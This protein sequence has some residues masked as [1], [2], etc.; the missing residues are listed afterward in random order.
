MPRFPRAG[1]LL[2]GTCLAAAASG[3]GAQAPRLEIPRVPKDQ[4][5]AFALYT[6]H[7]GVLKLTAQLYPLEASDPKVVRLEVERGG[8]WK[9]I[10]RALVVN[11]GWTA[12]FRV[13]GWD[14][15]HDVRYRVRHGEDAVFEGL[16]RKDPVDKEEIVVAAFTGNSNK[17]R[18]LKPDLIANLE[19]QD[20]DLLFFSGDQSYDHQDH[21]YAWLLFGRQFA[22]IVR[23]RPTVTIP[24]DH[25]VGQANLWGEGGK[26]SSSVAGDDG[27]YFM[28]PEYVNEVQRAQTSHLPDPWD[29]ALVDQGITVYYTALTVG[30]VSF[31]IVEDRKWKTGPL[32]RVPQMGPRPDHVGFPPP[33]EYDPGRVDVAGAELLGERQLAFLR[34]WAADWRGADMKAVLSQTVFSGTAHVHAGQRL[35][36]DLDSNGWPQ[37]GRRRA[38][39]EMRRGFAFHIAGDQ[40]LASVVRYGIEDWDDAGFAFCVPSIVN[41]YPREWKPLEPPAAPVEGPLEHLGR[42]RDGLGNRLTMHA[43]ANPREGVRVAELDDLNS[44]ASGYGLVRFDKRTRRI[45]V[46]CWPRFVDVTRED[47]RQF[48]GWPVVIDQADNDGRSPFGTLPT[49]EIESRADPVVQVLEEATGEIVYTLRIQGRRFTPRVFRPGRYTVRV[50]EPG[51]MT[52]LTGLEAG[53]G[54]APPLRVRVP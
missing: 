3:A 16:V 6:V 48:P 21:L 17:D 37:S 9:E 7:D 31:A 45:T 34:A 29:P 52:S 5:I 18:R 33:A 44:S 32:G 49:L 35:T 38:L 39:E 26:A 15:T 4:A 51:A 27:G 22:E 30:R 20:P 40:H 11:P 41:Y 1:R 19:A 43:Y 46:E 47:A 12:P 54:S 36:A 42:Y 24:D 8:A 25:D 13:T 2:A 50:G 14:A 10:A 28:S 23:D 53:R